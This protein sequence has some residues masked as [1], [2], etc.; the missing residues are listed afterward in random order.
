MWNF[1]SIATF[2][3][4]LHVKRWANWTLSEYQ[5]KKEFWGFTHLLGYFLFPHVVKCKEE[6]KFLTIM[7]TSNFHIGSNLVFHSIP[8]FWW[9]WVEKKSKRSFRIAQWGQ[10]MF[11]YYTGY[12][13]K[14]PQK[15]QNITHLG[16]DRE[17]FWSNF[18][19]KIIAE[20]V[21]Q[22]TQTF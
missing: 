8:T 7:A 5:W 6:K 20:G 17:E 1:T 11:E 15:Y 10:N 14:R 19:Y 18:I 3:N 9:W 22:L 12:S 16:Y 4:N 13:L 21:N 2:F